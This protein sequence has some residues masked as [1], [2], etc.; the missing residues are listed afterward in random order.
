MFYLLVV[1]CNSP[2]EAMGKSQIRQSPPAGNYIITQIGD[3]DAISSKLNI[4]FDDKSNQ[5]S[6]FAGCNTFFGRYTI[7]GNTIKFG[8]I[9]A[10]KKFCKKEINAVESEFL[11]VLNN[12]NSFSVKDKVLLLLEN[13]TVLLK[14]IASVATKKSDVIEGSYPVAITYETTSRGFYEY[15]SISKSNIA[16]SEDRSLQ[17]VSNYSCEESDWNALNSLIENID[18]ESLQILKAPSDKRLSDA[19]AEAS[20]TIQL[21]DIQYK[22]TTFDHGNPP[23]EIEALVNKV[24]SIKEK[25]IKQ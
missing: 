7:E 16:I 20:L 9:G 3:N 4:S 13:D 18:L 8:P 15:V 24:L 14:A 21:G 22:S 25:T 6:G 23:K 10:S 17:T 11:K 1:S 2:K 19:A 5:V 12:A